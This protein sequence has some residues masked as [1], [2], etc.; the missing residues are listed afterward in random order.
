MLTI[1]TIIGDDGKAYVD[2]GDIETNHNVII[3]TR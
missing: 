3:V 2:K 1:D